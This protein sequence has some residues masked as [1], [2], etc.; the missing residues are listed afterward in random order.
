MSAVFIEP[1]PNSGFGDINERNVFIQK[2]ELS[3]VLAYYPKEMS[4]N[5]N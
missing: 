3:F 4:L 5:N 2:G 1:L